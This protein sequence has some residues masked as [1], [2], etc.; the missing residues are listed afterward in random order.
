MVFNMTFASF[1]Q[2][3][4]SIINQLIA[5]AGAC[6][7][8]FFLY[9]VFNFVRSSGS[10]TKNKVGYDTIIWGLGAL[11]VLVAMGGIINMVSYSFFGVSSGSAANTSG[12]PLT[13]GF[14]LSG[15]C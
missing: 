6:A 4:V 3:V 11:V 5:V 12:S 1:V 7:L 10:V 9:G 8:V 2:Q 15:S 13:G 14:C